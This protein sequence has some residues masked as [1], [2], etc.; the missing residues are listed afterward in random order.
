MINEQV[1]FPQTCDGEGA[2][3]NSPPKRSMICSSATSLVGVTF[4]GGGTGGPF[5]NWEK[6]QQQINSEQFNQTA[7]LYFYCLMF[8]I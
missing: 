4:G 8:N 5:L 1:W 3:K 7:P 2:G 6:T